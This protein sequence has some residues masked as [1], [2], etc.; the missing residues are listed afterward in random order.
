M[1]PNR[2]WIYIA[3]YLENNKSTEFTEGMLD[4]G[5]G[6]GGAYHVE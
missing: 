6:F 2:Y 5:N 3:N 4:G 1:P